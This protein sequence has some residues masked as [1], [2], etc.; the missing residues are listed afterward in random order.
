[1][2]RQKR[3]MT[4]RAFTK[5]YQIGVSGRSRD[6]CPHT[7]PHLRQAWLTGWREGRVDNWNGMVGVSGLHRANETIHL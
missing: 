1:M 2:R 3:D 5:G 4:D 6:I 7:E